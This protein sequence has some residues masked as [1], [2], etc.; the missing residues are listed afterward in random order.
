MLF[1]N[2]Y[3]NFFDSKIR[4]NSATSDVQAKNIQIH[5]PKRFLLFGAG[6]INIYF[7]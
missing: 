2:E 1:Q 5:V 4:S 3:Y 7:Y 6:Y